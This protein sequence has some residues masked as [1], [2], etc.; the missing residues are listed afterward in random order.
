MSDPSTNSTTATS[1]SYAV[2]APNMDEQTAIILREFFGNASLLLW[3]FQLVPQGGSTEKVDEDVNIQS[4]VSTGDVVVVLD[5]M[6]LKERGSV[7]NVETVDATA[8]TIQNSVV[9]KENGYAAEKKLVWMGV[10][11]LVGL[12]GACAG[13]EVGLYFIVKALHASN[14]SSLSN[15]STAI[16]ST[17]PVLIVLGFVPQFIDIH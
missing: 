1:T 7:D 17:A 11:V 15:L 14:N 10:L 4:G 8:A 16:I 12:L 6:R 2:V 13:L 9:K 5:E 3:S